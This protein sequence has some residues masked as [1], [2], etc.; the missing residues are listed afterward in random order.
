MG[1]VT[2]SETSVKIQIMPW[3]RYASPSCKKTESIACHFRRRPSEAR[4]A[5]T[6]GLSPNL[7]RHGDLKDQARLE[8]PCVGVAEDQEVLRT[9]IAATTECNVGV[10]I[11]VPLDDPSADRL[12]SAQVVVHS[13]NRLFRTAGKLNDLQRAGELQLLCRPP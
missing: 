12:V 4:C 9:T 6:E 11:V 7:K 1:M 13:D 3:A 5:T 10:P 8:R 2:A